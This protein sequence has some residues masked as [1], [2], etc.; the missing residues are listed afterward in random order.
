MFVRLFDRALSRLHPEQLPVMGARLRSIGRQIWVADRE[1]QMPGGIRLPIRMVVMG[2]GR[3][4]LLCYSPVE[5]DEGTAEALD[6]LGKVRWI[7]A[8]NRYHRSFTAGCMSRYPQAQ[9]SGFLPPPGDGFAAPAAVPF[10]GCELTTVSLRT[11]F[12]EIVAYHDL[13]ETLV[14]AD[15]LF[16]VRNGNRRLQ[17]VMRVN[18]AWQKAGH[19][20]LQRW[21]I[22]RDPDGLTKF[23]RWALSRPFVQISMAHGLIVQEDA[24]ECLYRLQRGGPFGAPH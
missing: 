2:D 17:A 11:G 5:L 10:G 23:R 6:G 19:T 14:V 8:P 24:R 21:L 1:L 15:L 9:V 13:S 3:G 20:R 7:V 16:N 4:N 12:A 18:G 22:L